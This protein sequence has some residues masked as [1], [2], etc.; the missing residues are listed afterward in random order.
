M[1]DFDRP[2]VFQLVR[3][4]TNPATAGKYYPASNRI[5][6]V[7]QI[8]DEAS[9]K[10]RLIRYSL[11]EQSIFQDEQKNEKPIIGDIVFSNGVLTVDKR[12]TLLLDF[13]MNSNYNESNSNRMPN[14]SPIYR[15]V[16]KEVN[17]KSALEQM[18]LEHNAVDAAM[19][20]APQQIVGFATAMKWD[21][22][23]TM[24]ELK[25]DLISFAKTNPEGFLE[26][27]TDPA[28]DRLQ[29]IK[30]AIDFKILYADKNKREIGWKKGSAK[31]AIVDV[32]MGED[33]IEYFANWTLEEEGEKV[34]KQLK[35]KLSEVL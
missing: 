17:A 15:V 24:Y 34:F 7:D 4:A 16:D 5:P 1:R 23:R 18:E 27:A 12:E 2:V 30:D 21:T 22:T 8:Y 35:K 3:K 25:H 10:A 31:N 33:L 13:L 14:V 20:M 19:N 29:V 28:T 9:K 26:V 6:S 32:P 11:G